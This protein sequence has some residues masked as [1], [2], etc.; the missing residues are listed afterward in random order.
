MA[1]ADGGGTVSRALAIL[2]QP[3]RAWVAIAAAPTSAGMLI[4]RH[5]I[6]LAAIPAVGGVIGGL[7]FGFNI[8][9][10]GVR[11]SQPGLVL[12]AAAGYVATLAAVWLLAQWIALTAPAFEGVRDPTAALNLVGYAATASWVGGLAELYPSV[13]IPAG[14]LAALWSL[15]ALY[16][17]LAEMMRIPES[18]RLTAFATALVAVLLLGAARGLLVGW[19]TEL[20]GPLSASYAPR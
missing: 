19:T 15:Y 9:N 1:V 6:P 18:R 7:V 2:I 13:G 3:A 4:R 12:G 17:G 14:I 10:V 20:G 8:A 5:V 16:L 11:M